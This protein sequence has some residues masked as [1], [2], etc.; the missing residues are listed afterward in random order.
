[1]RRAVIG[2]AMLLLLLISI[3]GMRNANSLSQRCRSVSLR[4][5]QPLTTETVSTAQQRQ[6]GLTFWTQ[7]SALLQTGLHQIQSNVLYYHG[8]A[9]L[10]LGQ[11]CCSGKLPA[12]LDTSSCAI[13]TALARE[14]FGSE[15]VTGLSLLLEDS[16]FTVRG[17]F[18]SSELL[19][20]I[21]RND[22]GFTAV[23]LPYSE[24]ARQD[25]AA[26]VDVQLA[27]SGLPEPDW[28]L[29][30]GLCSALVK[31]L[32][33]LPLTFAFVVLTFSALHKLASWTFPARDAVLFVVL[34]AV[35]AALPALLAVWPSWFI[36]SRWSD[37]SWWGQ[38]AQTLGQRL[39]AFLLAPGMGRDLAIKTG[40]LAQAGIGFLQ[41]VLCEL[42]RCTLRPNT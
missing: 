16:S 21:P 30:T 13:S 35:A 7:D 29:Y 36:P 27:A 31:I 39:E 24:D 28:Q 6:P 37:F 40:L 11:D 5:R 34:L 2:L 4:Y 26:W 10:V 3:I 1:M 22:A 23:E 17:V 33:W 42:L 19:A 9:F 25:P 20:L 18:Q 12:L 32:A 38:T 41:C 8:D 14:L 15:E